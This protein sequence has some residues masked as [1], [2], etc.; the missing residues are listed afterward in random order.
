VQVPA[1]TI[2]IVDALIV[3]TVPVVEAKVTAR[4]DV[5]V[6]LTVKGGLPYDFPTSAAKM[7]VW[8]ALAMAKL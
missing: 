3:H 4:P 1:A 6:A 7:I 5:A 8:L 2:V